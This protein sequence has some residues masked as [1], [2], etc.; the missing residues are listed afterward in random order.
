MNDEALGQFRDGIGAFDPLMAA[1]A[2]FAMKLAVWLRRE[3]LTMTCY[4][5]GIVRP[6]ADKVT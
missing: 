4:S 1:I 6:T 5:R 2:A 3:Q